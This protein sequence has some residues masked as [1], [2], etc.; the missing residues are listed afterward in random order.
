MPHVI[1]PPIRVHLPNPAVRVH[2]VRVRGGEQ[3]EAFSTSEEHI[4]VGKGQGAMVSTCMPPGEHLHA[5][6]NVFDLGGAHT[7]GE[8]APW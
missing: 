5:E 2:A 7:C 3:A 1:D 4:P 6:G 8:R